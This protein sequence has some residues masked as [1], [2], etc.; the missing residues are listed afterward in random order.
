MFRID[1][2]ARY[3]AHKRVAVDNLV[4]E[5]ENTTHQVY[6]DLYSGKYERGVRYGNLNM[7]PEPN[8]YGDRLRTA[9]EGLR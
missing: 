5:K 4:S 6:E 9:L 3:T 8:R 7:R 2:S 1:L